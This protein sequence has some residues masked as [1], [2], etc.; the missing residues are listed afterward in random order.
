MNQKETHRNSGPKTRR[1]VFVAIA[2]LVGAMLLGL[3]LFIFWPEPPEPVFEGK[4]LSQWLEGASVGS[5]LQLRLMLISSGSVHPGT[6]EQTRAIKGFGTNALPF[7]V[8]WLSYK[9][10]LLHRTKR[11]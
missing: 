6:P 7:Y 5:T 4:R 11:F 3:G 9:P 2:T 8:K 10:S 1:R